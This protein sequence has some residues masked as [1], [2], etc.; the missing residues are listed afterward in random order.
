[1]KEQTYATLLARNGVALGELGLQEMSLRREDALAAIALLR[2]AGV[3]VLGGDVYLETAGAIE[4]AL[5]NWHVE[6]EAREG[7]SDFAQRSVRV[8]E[9]YIRRFPRRDGTT[10]LFVIVPLGD[11]PAR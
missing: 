4:G 9:E 10:P 3:P 11:I 8:A 7:L 5:S 6:R 2:A 1:M